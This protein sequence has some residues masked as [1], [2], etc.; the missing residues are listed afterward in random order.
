MKDRVYEVLTVIMLSRKIQWM[1]VIAIA[2]P[3]IIFLFRDYM[4]SDFHL[5]GPLA[6]MSDLLRESVKGKYDK[7]AIFCF[8]SFI[9]LAIKQYRKDKDRFL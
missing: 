1:L 3:L 5:S 8:I 2:G 9:A 6:P 7:A 4:L